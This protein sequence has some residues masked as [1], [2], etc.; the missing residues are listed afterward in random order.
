MTALLEKAFEAA[1]RLSPAEQDDI[2]R[3]ILR[4]SGVDGQS[5]L[6]EHET[7]AREELRAMLDATEAEGGSYSTDD[8]RRHVRARL[9]K[10]Q[11]ARGA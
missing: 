2:A 5:G 4:L 8:V 7:G 3:A 10:L 11:S 9:D 6:E 1:R